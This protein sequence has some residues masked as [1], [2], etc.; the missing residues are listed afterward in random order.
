M[1]QTELL[2]SQSEVQRLLTRVEDLSRDNHEMV[3]SKVHNQLLRL[4]DEKADRAERKLKE[5]ETEVSVNS[6]CLYC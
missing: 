5:I 6:L 1:F 3:S 2:H 4:A